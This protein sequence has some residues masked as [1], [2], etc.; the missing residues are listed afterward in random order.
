[1]LFANAVALTASRGAGLALAVWRVM[2]LLSDLAAGS[3]AG[4]PWGSA[5][6]LGLWTM[7]APVLIN[8]CGLAASWLLEEQGSD[9]KQKLINQVLMFGQ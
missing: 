9:S 1:L 3:R 2:G 5:Q 8:S 4:Q 7:L 6:R